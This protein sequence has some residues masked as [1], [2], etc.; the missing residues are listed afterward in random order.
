MPALGG[1]EHEA[2]NHVLR[3][4]HTRTSNTRHRIA[5]LVLDVRKEHLTNLDQLSG[6]RTERRSARTADV[7]GIVARLG[8]GPAADLRAVARPSA[9]WRRAVSLEPLVRP[10]RGWA[11]TEVLLGTSA[12]S[13]SLDNGLSQ[14]RADRSGM[15]GIARRLVRLVSCGV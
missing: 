2:P 14:F 12:K 8:R 9:R 6:R 4:A 13:R 15:L 3:T 11:M 10:H 1:L 7:I 5:R